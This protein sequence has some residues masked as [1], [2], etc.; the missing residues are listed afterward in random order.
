MARG[1]AIIRGS[2][3]QNNR[4]VSS[5]IE[6]PS[7][8]LLPPP[9]L[10]GRQLFG[11][12]RLGQSIE[13]E[14]EIPLAVR[15]AQFAEDSSAADAARGLRL[16]NR[17]D[18]LTLHRHARRSSTSITTKSNTGSEAHHYLKILLSKV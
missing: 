5:S 12:H 3:E 16:A 6:A 17:A 15:S 9:Q 18:L 11:I 4:F 14:N 2:A 8:G 1:C 7:H 10:A 13:V